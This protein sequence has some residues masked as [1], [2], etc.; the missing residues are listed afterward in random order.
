MGNNNI[1]KNNLNFKTQ[2]K[3]FSKSSEFANPNIRYLNQNVFFL[4]KLLFYVYDIYKQYH[5]S[6]LTIRRDKQILN[7]YFILININ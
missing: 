4:E 6:R 7:L 1:L 2:R 3:F 5:N